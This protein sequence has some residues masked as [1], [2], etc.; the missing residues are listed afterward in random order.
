MH[1]MSLCVPSSFL[2]SSSLLIPPL[3]LPLTWH[4]KNHVCEKSLDFEVEQALFHSL[5]CHSGAERP[6][7]N[8]WAS[9]SLRFLSW[10]TGILLALFREISSFCVVPGAEVVVC[11]YSS[12]PF[13]IPRRC[14]VCTYV[15]IHVFCFMK[16]CAYFTHLIVRH[17]VINICWNKVSKY[18]HSFIENLCL[19]LFFF[20]FV[21]VAGSLKAYCQAD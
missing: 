3:I 12:S 15:H 4:A 9:A 11:N 19:N 10:V 5:L 21:G 1:T 8:F 18:L 7:T 16:E 17:A 14:A 6:G 20:S 13:R 2:P